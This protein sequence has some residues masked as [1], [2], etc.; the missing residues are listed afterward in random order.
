MARV[1]RVRRLNDAKSE[2]IA[3]NILKQNPDGFEEAHAPQVVVMNHIPEYKR[4]VFLNG[5]DPGVALH[6]HYSSATHPLKH[7]TLYHGYEHEL[8]VEVIDHL[9]S[10]AENH[11]GYRKNV[12][13]DIEQFV[14][15]RKYI[16]SFR[17]APKKAA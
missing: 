15:S 17:N 12:H 5:R 11:Y 16:F 13:G 9:E 8:P 14:D 4:M 2:V 10:C 7:Y 1:Q 6:F 3:A